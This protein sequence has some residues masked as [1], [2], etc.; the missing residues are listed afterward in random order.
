[1]TIK[2]D[3]LVCFVFGDGCTLLI[4]LLLRLVQM[5]F[6]L[7]VLAVAGGLDASCMGVHHRVSH[8]YFYFVVFVCLKAF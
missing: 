4:A 1:M 3:F 2:K 7:R 8:V 5:L 6:V